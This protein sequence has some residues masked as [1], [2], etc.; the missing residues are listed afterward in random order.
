MILKI[1]IS[2]CK[3]DYNNYFWLILLTT[4]FCYD[5]I[6]LLFVLNYCIFW[7]MGYNLTNLYVGYDGVCRVEVGYNQDVVVFLLLILIF[8][9]LT[10]TC[11]N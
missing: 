8:S 2:Y 4:I 11:D 5:Y 10:H 6:L 3:H 7:E 1:Q 9:F